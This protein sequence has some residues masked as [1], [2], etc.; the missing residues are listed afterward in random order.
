MYL[1]GALH[2]AGTAFDT[3]D[4]AHGSP[5]HPCVEASPEQA[6]QVHGYRVSY[7]PVGFVCH[8]PDGGSYP[9]GHVPGYT[10]LAAVGLA[11]TAIPLQLLARSLGRRAEEEHWRRRL[12]AGKRSRS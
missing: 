7:L 5:A 8:I 10:D 2:V 1:W 12:A 3:G 11:L 9:A 6:D 4:G